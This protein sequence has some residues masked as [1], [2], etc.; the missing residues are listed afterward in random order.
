MHEHTS[1]SL[2][3]L[4][5]WL[6]FVSSV[7]LRRRRERK[8][9]QIT[10]S[11]YHNIDCRRRRTAK[12]ITKYGTQIFVVTSLFVLFRVSNEMCATDTQVFCCG[13]HGIKQNP[14]TFICSAR[15]QP[16]KQQQQQQQQRYHN[17]VQLCGETN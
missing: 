10:E 3:L 12:T 4:M 14:V 2:L 13:A 1:V 5:F 6:I 16:L 15:R 11:K 7:I 8:K 17:Q 9:E